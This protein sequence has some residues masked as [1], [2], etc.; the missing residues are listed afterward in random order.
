MIGLTRSAALDYAAQNIRVNAV[1]PGYIDTPMMGRFTGGTAEGRAKVIG[2]CGGAGRT[3][4]KS[5]EIA[6]AVVWLGAHQP[7]RRLHLA[8][9]QARRTG[10]VPAATGDRWGLTYDFFRFVSRSLI[11]TFLSL[12]IFSGKDE[13]NILSQQAIR[14]LDIRHYNWHIM[15]LF[16]MWSATFIGCGH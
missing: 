6:A 14:L 10:Q 7:D 8:A 13:R 15:S 1:C 16:F 12:S 5:E 3:D 9:T 4:G 2:D 11:C